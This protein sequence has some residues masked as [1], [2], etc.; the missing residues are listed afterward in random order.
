MKNL[1][2]KARVYA[3]KNAA[4]HGGKATQGAV[5]SG[6]FAEGLKKGDVGKYIKDIGEILKEVNSLEPEEQKVLFDKHSK[7]IHER[8]VREGLP[9]LPNAKKG[10]VVM[11]F[12]PS[13][14]GGLHVGH[15]LTASLNIVYVKMYKGKFICRIEDTNPDNIYPKAYKL[16]EK[17]IGWLSKNKAKVII[18]SDRIDVYYNYAKKLISKGVAYVC[19]CTGDDFREFVKEKKNCPCR[20][21]SVKDNTSDWSRM[22]DEFKAGESVLRFKSPEGMKHPNPAFRDF[23]LA[24]INEVEHPRQ[25]NKYKVWPLMN[26]AVAADDI[27][28]GVTHIIRAKEHRDNAERQR[29][30]F[31]SLGKKYPWA[32]FLGRWH[33]KDMEL[34]ASKITK[35][36]ESG[37]Y[38][39]WADP[40]LPTLQALMKKY[41]PEAF[42]GVA[43]QRGLSEVDKVISSKDFFE[44]LERFNKNL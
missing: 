24:R 12:S 33:F 31:E 40:K 13:P 34:S 19:T 2:E 22:F 4:S 11:R 25:K 14:S 41:K 23:P 32:A 29:M 30:I 26:L 7:E 38:K 35:G 18:Q 27:E 20:K 1:K 39:N 42:W 3:L 43:E 36:V 28:M 17:D 9:I 8:E 5:I 37:K 21:K 15:A 6:L 44:L 16:I 10:K